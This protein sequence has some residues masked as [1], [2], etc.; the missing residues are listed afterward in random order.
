MRNKGQGLIV[1]GV[2]A[3]GFLLRPGGSVAPGQREPTKAGASTSATADASKGPWI[4]SCNYWTPARV[5]EK[6]PPNEPSEFH[7]SF[8]IKNSGT[9][10]HITLNGTSNSSGSI[11]G[12]DPQD[13]WGFPDHGPINVTS[14]IATVPDP[15]HSHLALTLDRTV[16]AI[17]QAAGDNAYLSSYYWLPWK[18]QFGVLTPEEPLG[19]AEP[20]HDPERERNPG[21]IILKHRPPEKLPGEPPPP[22]SFYNVVYLFLVAE[23]PTEGVDGVQLQNA[24]TFEEELEQAVKGRG[25]SRGNGRVA[26]IGPMYSGSAASLRA[27]IQKA[28]RMYPKLTEFELA[29]STATQGAVDAFT[30]APTIPFLSFG[31][32]TDYEIK[33]LTDPDG[34]FQTSGYLP[35]RVALLIEDSTAYASLTLDTYTSST[36]GKRNRPVQV[37][38]FPRE[39]SLLRNAQGGGGH[40]GSD[41]TASGSA[42]S[43]FLPF[44]LKDSSAYDSVPQFSRDN[45]PVSQEAQLMTIG[46]QLHRFRSQFIAI[47]ASNVLDQVFLAQFLHRAC[48]EARLVF[49]GGDL[50]MVREIDNVPF[51]GSVTVTPYSLLGLEQPPDGRPVRAYA[52]SQSL[53]VYNAA[54]YTF[55]RN[56]LSVFSPNRPVLQGYRSPLTPSDVQQPPLWATVIGSD[57]Y[58][59]LAIL[60]PC[61]SDYDGLLKP[62]K[63][64]TVEKANCEVPSE[65]SRQWLDTVTIFPARLWDIL[66][67]LVSLLCLF[68]MSM[69][70]VAAYRWPFTRDLAIR[71]NDQPRRRSTYAHVATVALFSMA[72]IVSFPAISLS[73]MTN[74]NPASTLAGVFV[75]GAGLLTVV[76]T[77]WKTRGFIWVTPQLGRPPQRGTGLRRGYDRV[78]ENIYLL[79]NLLVWAMLLALTVLWGY[80]CVTNSGGC[81][82]DGLNLVGLSFS[83]RSVNPGSG[84][85]PVVPVLLLLSGWYLWAF[86]QTWRL[87]FSDN[88]RPWLPA[89]VGDGMDSV[90]LFVSD[91]SLS[92]CDSPKDCCLYN[93]IT[94]L[95]ITREILCRFWRFRGNPVEAPGA[96]QT[97]PAKPVECDRDDCMKV[98]IFLIAVYSGLL[99]SFSLFSPIRGLDHF[100][101]RTGR[102]FSS[103]YEILVGV[104]FFPLIVMC[105][106]GWLR[107]LL[108][109]GA[110]KRGLLER[111]ENQPL[112]FAFSRLKVMGW[113]T[114]LRHG[115]T[116]EQ[117]ID[118]A[119]SLES[120]RQ[121]IHQPDLKASLPD[122]ERHELEDANRGLLDLIGRLF[123]E[124]GGPRYDSIKKIEIEFAAFSQK[125]LTTV[126]IP[127][128]KNERV[129]LVAS[130][131]IAELPI[132]ARRS[133]THVEHPSLPMELHAGPTSEEPARILVAEEFLAIRYISLIRAVLS[134]MR[135][136]MIFVSASF[137]LAMAAWNSYPFQPRQWVDW[138]FTG[139]MLFLGSGVIWVF[140]QMHRNPILSRITDT[141]A[142]E[143]GWDFYLRIA[144]YG[145]VPVLAWLTYQF[146]DVGSIISKFLQPGVPVLK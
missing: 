100:L 138:L 9:D 63:G 106:A 66:A 1:S 40:P 52:D 143:L 44:S 3:A 31:D 145:A 107:M 101:W 86:C 72:F 57:G 27:G 78:H 12:G 38:R 116:Q 125:L 69:L 37:I 88:G 10:L 121:M 126:L 5:P 55:W 124:A 89:K 13:R 140:A 68:H 41:S 17:L 43:P 36:V 137:V 83:Y 76:V 112:R 64:G 34:F 146:P 71:D 62:I 49:F 48:P 135:Y 47:V 42:A 136:L 58:Y 8:D 45:T 70:L 65:T 104:L 61:A 60:S 120:M 134:N 142:N 98:D 91:D 53:A 26:I 20:N 51:I 18:S 97:P 127:Y 114:M 109:W 14:I 119:R 118:M 93:N 84:V 24:F 115:G 16:G 50:L 99:F 144:S 2:I 39:I 79:L 74:L 21:L 35:E 33:K 4:A 130:E 77:F 81:R 85:S 132:K 82:T 29:G 108:V 141:K 122:S 73:W 128:W 103:P 95:L 11:C 19:D 25:F 102:Y 131:E 113:M 133:E 90:V 110:L 111:L 94:S 96:G 75:L 30:E 54:S 32:N 92:S 67:A 7:N 56:G 28:Q 6:L 59:P 23:T 123:K 22:E 15:V 87:R 117:R 139:F 46:R 105:L 80:L 129:G